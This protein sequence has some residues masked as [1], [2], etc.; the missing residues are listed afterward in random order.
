MGWILD[1]TR[2]LLIA[3]A[4][5]GSAAEKKHKKGEGL[6]LPP[7]DQKQPSTGAK[8]S[9]NGGAPN[10]SALPP[11]LKAPSKGLSAP[12]VENTRTIAAPKRACTPALNLESLFQQPDV[13]CP[14]LAKE[15]AYFLSQEGATVS[16]RW[17]KKPQLSPAS[18]IETQEAVSLHTSPRSLTAYF[19]SPEEV[20]FFDGN[21][22]KTNA[23]P[24]LS[25]LLND[26]ENWAAGISLADQALGTHR[27]FR[28]ELQ[29]RKTTVL[30]ELTGE[31]TVRALS[32]DG[33]KIALLHSQGSTAWEIQ[34]WNS[35]GN[36][37]K[38]LS[39]LSQ[40]SPIAFS[41]DGTHLLFLRRL[42]EGNG[43]LVSQHIETGKVKPLTAASSDVESFR[44]SPDRTRLVFAIWQKGQ[45]ETR[46]HQL[47]RSGLLDRPMKSPTIDGTLHGAPA[48]LNASSDPIIQFFY[49]ASSP[50]SPPSLWFWNGTASELWSAST[51]SR[52][53]SLCGV[54]PSRLEI[55]A[56]NRPLGASFFDSLTGEKETLQKAPWVIYEQKRFPHRER[57]L[58]AVQYLTQR[59]YRVLVPHQSGSSA[60]WAEW[61]TQ[62]RS[63]D[64][65]RIW[66]FEER[67]QGSGELSALRTGLEE[68]ERRLAS[69]PTP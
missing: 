30:A 40:P 33:K 21:G 65:D 60:L 50:V 31:N 32:P 51:A 13:R 67:D 12:K 9:K 3:L 17:Q 54:W 57:F 14:E 58:P 45:T 7:L 27:L 47:T 49:A 44:L 37:L 8:D 38:S 6:L 66:I 23:F 4:F 55:E 63:L 64:K 53:S 48:V 42:T 39:S 41:Q 61:I 24:T 26:S 62:H 18:L 43:Q 69:E 34:I 1:L 68:F 28:L 35:Q 59:Q 25:A 11:R 19:Q 56:G 36:T 20:A 29:P 10:R 15:G 2:V 46:A 22:Q 5:S 16:V 52:S